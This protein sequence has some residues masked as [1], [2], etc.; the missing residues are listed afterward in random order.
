MIKLTNK[1]L[2]LLRKLEGFKLLG[3]EP[4]HKQLAEVVGVQPPA[5]TYMLN[6]LVEKG[7]VRKGREWRSIQILVTSS[8]YEQS[9]QDAA[10][11]KRANSQKCWSH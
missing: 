8:E 6:T 9:V 7:V 4:T 3:I 10:R 5:I 1:Q 2:N 11:I